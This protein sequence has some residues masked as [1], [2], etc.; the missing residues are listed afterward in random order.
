MTAYI[1]LL[2]KDRA[3]DYGVG[4]PGFPGCV[5]VGVGLGRRGSWPP[6]R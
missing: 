1:A 6:R 5:M 4:F 2:R 3:S